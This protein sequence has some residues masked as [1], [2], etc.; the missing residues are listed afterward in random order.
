MERMVIG[1]RQ[2][3]SGELHVQGSKNLA[4][5]VL[6]ACLLIPE[7][8]VLTHCPLLSDVEETLAMLQTLGVFVKREGHTVFC[9]AKDAAPAKLSKEVTQGNRMSILLLGAMLSRFGCGEI[10]YPGGCRIGKRP[11]DLH[12]QVFSRFGAELIALN[13]E[14]WACRKRR[15]AARISLPYPS[16]GA[17]Q[18]AILCAC[19][20][21]GVSE[22]SGAAKEPE[23]AGLCRFLIGAG[24]KIRGVGTSKL[25][26]EGVKG[27]RGTRFAIEGDR[28]VAGTYLTAAAMS[29]G[30]CLL[31][32]VSPN[33]LGSY[34]EFLRRLG[35]EV[36]A[37]DESIRLRAPERLIS[38]LS[39]KTEPYPG[40][41]TDLQ[42]MAVGALCVARG[43]ANV[44][45][46]IFEERF[47]AAREMQ[48]FGARLCI[49]PPNVSIHG[50]EK[51][52]GACVQGR[53]LRGSAALLLMALC[54]QG[55]SILEGVEYLNR[56][57]ED[58]VRDMALL[59][60]ADI[61]KEEKKW[62]SYE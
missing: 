9:D 13:D 5:P 51:H 54:A 16:V 46:T 25:L 15:S 45:E 61:R 36:S 43:D 21:E 31:H 60:C 33:R 47:A 18:N 49:A 55:E 27:L 59:G 7:P 62:G 17:T 22:I 4:L 29:G 10:S 8:V 40:F 3:V 2:R 56:G 48:K 35:C 44:E 28:I 1:G 50:V 24:A 30:E 41:P 19:L 57:Y 11:L 39:V 53:D 20:S 32:G 34:L 38:G 58:I 26:I 14:M 6:C 37:K 52:F 42:P 12:E 23:V